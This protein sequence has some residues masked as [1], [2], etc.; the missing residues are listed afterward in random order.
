[1]TSRDPS[2]A[3]NVFGVSYRLEMGRIHTCTVAAEVIQ[4]LALWDQTY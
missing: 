2:T 1:M 3:E 4:F